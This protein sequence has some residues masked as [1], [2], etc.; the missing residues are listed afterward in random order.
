M[1]L[2]NKSNFAEILKFSYNEIMKS[3]I[4]INERGTFTLPKQLRA[5]YGFVGGGIAIVED[6]A[7][8]ILIRPSE[9]Y[10]IEIYSEERMEEFRKEEEKLTKLK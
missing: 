5:K 9:T 10:P 1:K 4:Q 3:L 8:G 2:F 7:E 6:T